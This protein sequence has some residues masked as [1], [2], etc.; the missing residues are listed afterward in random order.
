[1]KKETLKDKI[2]SWYWTLMRKAMNYT[3]KHYGY[4]FGVYYMEEIE[5]IYQEVER[6]KLQE[7]EDK[8]RMKEADEERIQEKLTQGII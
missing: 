7:D 2:I 6:V 8:A 5:K 3:L 4:D 1:M